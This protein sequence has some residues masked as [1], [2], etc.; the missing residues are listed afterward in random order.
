MTAA[1][2]NIPVV[3]LREAAELLGVSP[4]AAESALRHAGIKSGYPLAAVEWLA[5]N[6]PGRGA[7]TDL[8]GP[9]V[10]TIEID[11]L[12]LP[13]HSH[14]TMLTGRDMTTGLPLAYP[15]V[16]ADR[17]YDTCPR[18]GQ[19]VPGVVENCPALLNTGAGQ[20]G[21]IQEWDQQHGCGEWLAVSWCEVKPAGDEVTEAEIQ[22][23]AEELSAEWQ[24]E[25]TAKTSRIV[26][27]LRKELAVALARLAEPLDEDETIE[28]RDEEVRTGSETQ[29]GVYREDG[30][31]LAWSYPPVQDGSDS[32][33]VYAS[34]LM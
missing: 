28:D 6:R 10:A 15:V 1:K 25:V 12:R 21:A 19:P 26:A 29:P 8:K 34:D 3:P 33:T 30:E 2:P 13:A 22:A 24:R 5:S 17:P 32:I 9:A 4:R 31:W 11:E 14:A 18:C 23:A 20:G 27:A 7:R 16:W